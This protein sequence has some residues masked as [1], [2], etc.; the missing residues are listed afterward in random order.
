[1]DDSILAAFT[2]WTKG[3]A[4][5]AARIALF[6][7]VRDIPYQ[8]PSSRDPVEV[9]KTGRGSASAKHYLLGALKSPARIHQVGHSDRNQQQHGKQQQP[10][11]ELQIAHGRGLGGCFC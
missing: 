10:R 2:E 11:L 7:H 6:E 1:M 4:P 8:E 3:C 5:L 9:L